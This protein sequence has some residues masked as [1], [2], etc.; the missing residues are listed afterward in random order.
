MSFRDPTIGE[1][2]TQALTAKKVNLESR[3]DKLG[4]R[5]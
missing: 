5:D 2:P 1:E 4:R 3:E